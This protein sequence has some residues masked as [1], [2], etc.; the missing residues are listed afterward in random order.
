[1]AGLINELQEAGCPGSIHSHRDVAAFLVQHGFD[2]ISDMAFAPDLCTLDGWP[3]LATSIQDFLCAAKFQAEEGFNDPFVSRTK[4]AASTDPPAAASRAKR[5]ACS[6]A[7]IVLDASPE[8]HNTRGEGPS[9]SLS[10]L[11][12]SGFHGKSKKQWVAEAKIAALLGSFPRSKASTASGIRSWMRFSDQV[13]GL[14]GRELP[15]TADG[16]IAWSTLFRSSATFANY[17]GYVRVA[18]ELLG[19]STAVFNE[20]ESLL[21]RAKASIDKKRHFVPRKPL[22]IRRNMVQQLMQVGCDTPLSEQHAY[23]FLVC[24]CFLLRLPSEG[25]PIARD[26]IGSRLSIGNSALIS[27]THDE[28]ILKLRRRKNKEGGSVL[29]RGCWCDKCAHTCPLH[30]IGPFIRRHTA[31]ERLF[32][33]ITG[34]SALHH[35]RQLLTLLDVPNAY[36]YRTHDLRRGH[37]RDLQASGSSLC[38]ILKAG[39]WRSAAFMAYLDTDQLQSDAVA[40]AARPRSDLDEFFDAI[41]S[42]D[43]EH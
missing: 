24:Y 31:G 41:S 27:V 33:G 18:C 5:A 3:V 26:S 36:E 16:L 28:I 20:T 8:F 30:V 38:E 21:R 40:E 7:I 43:E 10:R 25:I 39:E 2:T 35:L 11:T 6:D 1:M 14:K 4:R 37:A 23:L 19:L 34:G 9:V 42:S 15:P 12:S 32:A 29:R 13:L 22:F 17:V